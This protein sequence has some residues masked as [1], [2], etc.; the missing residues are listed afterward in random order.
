LA[1]LVPV[2]DVFT[3]LS[4]PAFLSEVE[5]ARRELA[6]NPE[7]FPNLTEKYRHLIKP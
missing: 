2:A 3:E 4:E 5:V 7:R 1:V 6:D